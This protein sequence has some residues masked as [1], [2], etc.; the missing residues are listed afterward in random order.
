MQ[1]DLSQLDFSIITDHVEI[2]LTISS[3]HETYD[4][5]ESEY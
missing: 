2:A 5:C 1:L 3:L 4:S